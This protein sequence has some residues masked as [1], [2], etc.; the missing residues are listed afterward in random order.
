MQGGVGHAVGMDGYW[1][2]VEGER[3]RYRD[4]RQRRALITVSQEPEGKGAAAASRVAFRRD[5]RRQLGSLNLLPRPR[6]KLAVDL[7]FQ[8]TA[9][10]PPYLQNLAKHYLDL[11]GGTH[12]PGADPGP[13]LFNDDAQVGLLHVSAH[14][15]EGASGGRGTIDISTATR[16]DVLADLR[17]AG[18]LLLG[19]EDLLA[20]TLWADD[21]VDPLVD[22]NDEAVLVGVA[23]QEDPAIRQ[24]ATLLRG[25]DDFQAQERLLAAND[26]W[27]RHQFLT[28]GHRLLVRQDP[29]LERLQAA[30]KGSN[31][32]IDRLM[33]SSM[34]AR[35]D[36]LDPLLTVR[37]P[38]L[39][40]RTGQGRDYREGIKI[41]FADAVSSHR[42]FSRL[43]VP[44]SVTI[45]VAP[46]ARPQG[47]SGR[48]LDNVMIDVLTQLHAAIRPPPEPSVP[49][50]AN[51][52]TDKAHQS[53][54]QAERVRRL[55][56]Q[57]HAVTACQVIQLH[58]AP[59][60]PEGLL[61]VVLGHGYK[62]F[63]LWTEAHHVID[64][65][66]DRL[67]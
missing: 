34:A 20:D 22:D 31:E 57:G 45:I 1:G 50:P 21:Q 5:V 32:V 39:P 10:Q 65:I 13:V 4:R 15:V 18:N 16:A 59:S 64:D 14:A 6:A 41:A 28:S 63:S 30:F 35:D 11:L 8:T 49:M 43:L 33:Q 7:R 51:L 40:T 46:P 12:T 2:S 24:V 37:L 27:L 58:P 67:D 23:A 19:H 60:D 55:H 42:L 47:A 3:H 56:R 26:R 17:L 53:T 38:P 66:F 44:V 48:D 52:S 61:V 25:S 54:T 62:Q 29:V 36:M 9:T